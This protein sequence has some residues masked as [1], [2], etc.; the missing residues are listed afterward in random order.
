MI[1]TKVTPGFVTQRWDADNGCWLDQSFVASDD[2]TWEDEFG[3]VMDPTEMEG[4]EPY[5]PFEMKQPEE[6]LS[7]EA[8]AR[9]DELL[10]AYAEEITDA[11]DIGDV[12]DTARSAIR[13]E[14]EHL[15]LWQLEERIKAD[16]PELLE[17]DDTPE[18]E[19][20]QQ[21]RDEKNGLYPEHWDDC[22]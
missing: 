1:Y 5:L 22:N 10:D 9:F 13:A 3:E 17:E 2:V 15:K 19:E 16:F 8:A 20:E 14:Y 12:L 4:D 6:H 11:M 7:L 18:D 21:R